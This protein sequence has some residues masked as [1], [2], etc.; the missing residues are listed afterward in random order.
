M[1]GL[2][3]GTPC[4]MEKA[5]TCFSLGIEEAQ[6]CKRATHFL[7]TYDFLDSVEAEMIVELVGW[8]L[9]SKVFDEG[10]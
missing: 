5:W 8:S 1:S 9:G 10:L 7:R 2:E 4:L 6:E 3:R